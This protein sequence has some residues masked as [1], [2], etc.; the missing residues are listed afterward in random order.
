MK[1]VVVMLWAILLLSSGLS[2]RGKVDIPLR[3]EARL[4]WCGYPMY[5][6]L[7]FTCYGN[8]GIYNDTP[9]KDVFVS[10]Q[11]TTYMTGNIVA[12]FD[13]QFNEWFSLAIG[14]G[15]DTIWKPETPDNDKET[16]YVLSLMPQARFY[17]LNSEMVRMYSS[18][19]VGVTGGRLTGTYDFVTDCYPAAQI[20]PVGICVGRKV[21]G[22]AEVG[23][24]TMYVGGMIGVGY[25]F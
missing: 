5:D 10:D 14:F 19:G 1:R 12:E 15:V 13:F 11:G 23:Y 7:H 8:L 20:I 9:V 17:W 4:G 18:L 24:G 2:A 22:F 21:F 3:Y 16:G 6:D 25:S